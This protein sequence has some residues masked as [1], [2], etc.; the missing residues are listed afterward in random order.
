[1]NSLVTTDKKILG[2]EFL[3]F[4]KITFSFLV[5]CKAV[6]LYTKLYVFSGDN[7]FDLLMH[8]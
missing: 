1:M 4:R 2:N 3:S 8:W 5:V 6:S 7:L